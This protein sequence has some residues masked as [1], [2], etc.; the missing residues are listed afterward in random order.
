MNRR[1]KIVAFFVRQLNKYCPDIPVIQAKQDL[2]VKYSRCVVV[3]LISE[4]N[5]GDQEQWDKENELIYIVGLR[6]AT[7]NIQA[8]GKGSIELLGGVWGYLERPT[9][10]D[11][12]QNA[13][14]AVNTTG[15]VQDLTSLLDNRAYLERAS[16]DLTITYD[17]YTVDNPEWFDVVFITGVL[18]RKNFAD[19]T[20]KIL[21]TKT[22]VK[23]EREG[24]NGKH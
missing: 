23:I 20:T 19:G 7:L 9:V 13:N 17:R 6:E 5:L 12:F 2:A 3:D 11:E 24:E 18:T 14:I 16:V 10:V 22:D 21:K 15:Q 1:E 4:R 8:Y